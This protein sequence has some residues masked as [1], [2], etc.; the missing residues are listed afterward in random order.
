MG[1]CQLCVCCMDNDD[2]AAWKNEI[3]DP[4][5]RLVR[6]SAM[7]SSDGD[8]CRLTM[9]TSCLLEHCSTSSLLVQPA[10]ESQN[11]VCSSPI[12]YDESKWVERRV[13]SEDGK[14]MHTTLCASGGR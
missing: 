14:R 8:H 1:V 6:T 13:K 5:V 3:D 9:M 2:E 12:F 7:P 11:C 4:P 10:L